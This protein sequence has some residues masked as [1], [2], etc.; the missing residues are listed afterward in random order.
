MP[1]RNSVELNDVIEPGQSKRLVG[2]GLVIEDSS[3]M[4]RGDL[5]ITF[6]VN[7]PSSIPAADQ[8]LL[9]SILPD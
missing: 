9:K 3:G 4:E 1:E 5:V 2:H 7:F 6:Q 8:V